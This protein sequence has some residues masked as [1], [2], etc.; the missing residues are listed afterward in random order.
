[1]EAP[2]PSQP[3]VLNAGGAV[4]ASPK[5]VPVFFASEDSA[6]KAEIE[7]FLAALAPSSYWTAITQEY[8]VGAL[9]IAPSVVTAETLPATMTDTEL[10]TMITSHAG[11]TGGWPANDANTIY[12]MFLPDRKSVV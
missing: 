1:M 11:G 7:S 3:I 8:G 12:A 9:T 2:H 4:L 5:V 6:A 10:Q